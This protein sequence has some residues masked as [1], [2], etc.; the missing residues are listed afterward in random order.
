[1]ARVRTLPVTFAQ[2]ARGPLLLF[3]AFL[4]WYVSDRLVVIG[5]FDRAQIGWAVV[6]PLAALAPGVAALAE[7]DGRLIRASRQ[8]AASVSV[9]L[10]V[11]VLGALAVTVTFANCRPV[12][13]PMDV[14][15]NAI[16]TALVA[17][18]SYW[19]AYLSAAGRVRQDKVPLSVLVG[20]IVWLALAGLTVLVLFG[21][22]FPPISCAPPR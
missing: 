16:P 8:V 9:G 1:M 4:V 19:L 10:G 5:P 15:P 13:S 14:L 12:T 3:A 22:S 21:V 11:F 2:L 7:R 18:A 20:A 17:G 6:A